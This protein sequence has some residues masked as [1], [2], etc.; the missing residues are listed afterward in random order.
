MAQPS[1]LVFILHRLIWLTMRTHES[2]HCLVREGDAVVADVFHKCKAGDGWGDVLGKRR[3][4]CTWMK[5]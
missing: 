5:G 2:V 3:W 4:L 1:K